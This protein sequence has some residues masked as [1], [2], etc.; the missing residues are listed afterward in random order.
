MFDCPKLANLT[1]AL[2]AVN[3]DVR[4]LLFNGGKKCIN[5]ERPCRD[6]QR[7]CAELWRGW[8]ENHRLKSGSHC[9]LEII[10]QCFKRKGYVNKTPLFI[11]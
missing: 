8:S 3:Y 2:A 7:W 11:I 10:L 4:Q 1:F 9:R 5:A 6:F